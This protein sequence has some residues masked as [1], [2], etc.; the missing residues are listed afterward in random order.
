MKTTSSSKDS[1]AD[2]KIDTVD[3]KTKS[4]RIV[5]GSGGIIPD[6]IVEQQILTIPIRALYGK[7]AFFQFANIEY[8][9]L[10]K[11]KVKIDQDFTID[12]NVM[13]DFYSYLDSIKFHLSEYS[14]DQI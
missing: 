4:G 11:K 1:L 6:S 14:T 2:S 10:K 12:G 13:K 7:D 8:P 9:R 5:H 3:Y